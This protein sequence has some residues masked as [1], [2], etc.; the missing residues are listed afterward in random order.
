MLTWWSI[1]TPPSSAIMTTRVMSIESLDMIHT[2]RLIGERLCNEHYE[3]IHLMHQNEAV[4]CHLGGKRSPEKTR[5]YFALNLAHWDNHGYGIWVLRETTSNTFV[6]RGGL[7]N[8]V[9]NESQEIEIAYGLMPVF[10]QKGLATE[11]VRS[12]VRIAFDELGINS[13]VSI[14]SPDNHA[15]RHVLKK[16]GFSQECEIPYSG[17]ANVLYRL[18]NM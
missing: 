18:V 7:R 17:R 10:W 13:L 16:C 9:F 3:F 2:D 12:L 11:F 6:G 8:T 14:T 5:A 1:D 15:S 4:M